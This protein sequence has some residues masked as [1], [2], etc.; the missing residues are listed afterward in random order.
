MAQILLFHSLAVQH[1]L[2]ERA[3]L[4]LDIAVAQH[5]KQNDRNNYIKKLEQAGSRR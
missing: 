2:R 3:G 1:A 4:V 5:A